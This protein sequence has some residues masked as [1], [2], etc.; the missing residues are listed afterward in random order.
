M[1]RQLMIEG[2]C[3]F[4]PMRTF[5]MGD[6]HGNHRALVQCLEKSEFDKKKDRLIQLG[7]VVDGGPDSFAC[8]EE[9]LSIKHLIAIRGNH[10]DWFREFIETGYHS[11]EWD[12]G[13]KATAIS[14]LKQSGRQHLIR[15]SGRGYKNALDQ[16]DIPVTHQDFFKSQLPYYIDDDNN[17]YV[18][19][20]FDRHN[21]FH[22]QRKE[23]YFWDRE[24]WSDAL[25][26]LAEELFNRNPG[27][28]YMKT[29]FNNIFIGHTSTLH[30]KT[31][32]PMKAGNIYNLDTGAGRG[33]KLTIMNVET[34]K[35]FQSEVAQAVEAIE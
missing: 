30:W 11:C 31:D 28:F 34:K 9:L 4:L 10:D 5:V 27:L 15:K 2:D 7:D 17:C 25:I 33:G 26:H 24:L 35:W 23:L 32:H 16:K 29:T 20:G 12:F 19:A 18:H 22:N 1:I 8:V 13:G 14:Y 3:L 6:I 21:T